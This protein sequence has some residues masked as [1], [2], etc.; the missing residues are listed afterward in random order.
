MVQDTAEYGVATNEQPCVGMSRS[1]GEEKPA[2]AT[3]RALTALPML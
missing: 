1:D 3:L 2:A